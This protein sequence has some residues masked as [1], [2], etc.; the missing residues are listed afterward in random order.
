M[1]MTIR[2]SASSYDVSFTHRDGTVE[3][4][5]RRG[6]SR[7][8]DTLLINRVKALFKASRRRNAR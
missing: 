3:T 2:M 7:Q 4:I 5:N 6:L 1:S 8:D